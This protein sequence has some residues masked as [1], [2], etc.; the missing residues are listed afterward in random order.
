MLILSSS[1]TT[2]PNCLE[3]Q[4]VIFKLG[5]CLLKMPPIF[6]FFKEPFP[7]H[8][9]VHVLFGKKTAHH[10]VRQADLHINIIS[11]WPEQTR[12]RWHRYYL[13]CNKTENYFDEQGTNT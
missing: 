2:L 6:F 11:M 5:L 9:G 1:E 8:R 7:G 12:L 10:S 13:T 3:F 4:L